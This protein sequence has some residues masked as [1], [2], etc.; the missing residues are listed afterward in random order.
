[1]LRVIF[2]RGKPTEHG[3]SVRVNS[4]GL[5]ARRSSVF[6]DQRTLPTKSIRFKK[7][8]EVTWWP[9]TGSPQARNSATEQRSQI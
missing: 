1:M 2:V 8:Q 3:M 5:T 6:L 9:M 7:C 4:V